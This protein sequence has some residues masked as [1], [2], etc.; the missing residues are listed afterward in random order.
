[1]RILIVTQIYL[2]E[3][4]A[5]SSRLYPL[6]RQL[7]AD[8][9]DV[10][11]ATGMPN[12]PAGV[13]FPAYRGKFTMSEEKDGYRILRTHYYTAPRNR[14]KASQLASYL[15]FV[16]AVLLSGLRGGKFDVVFI[17]SPPIF[18]VLPAALLAK[19]RGAKLVFDIRDLWS[20]ELAAYGGMT[21]RS[22][23]VRAA[24]KLENWGYRR[25]DLIT[26]TTESLIETIVARGGAPEKT[27]YLPNGADLELFKPL[28]PNNPI[29]DEYGFGDRF[30]VMYSGLFGI[31]HGLEI[32]LEAAELLR[33]RKDIVFFLLGNGARRESLEKQI[34]DRGLDNV[35][36]GGERK[37]EEI[38]S[39]IARADVCFAAVRPEPY[40]KKLIS[41]KIFEYLACEKPVVGSVSGESA[42]IIDESGGGLVVAPGDARATAAAI[43]RLYRNPARR[44]QMGRDGRR[45]VTENFSRSAWAEKFGQMLLGLAGRETSPATPERE[46]AFRAEA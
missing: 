6:V 44:R 9:H 26:T 4:G 28:A 19:A 42:R 37:I 34:A 27:F 16:P 33:R 36:I 11:V 14:S 1:M 39:I 43:L 22:A 35:V 12:Y 8:G 24:R 15:A 45:Y 18:P 40:P 5:L 17:T 31:K 13:V 23:A 3:M 46:K 2:P 10:C 38:P 25:A 30:V 32:L 7:V 21:E 20:D 41:V 29:A